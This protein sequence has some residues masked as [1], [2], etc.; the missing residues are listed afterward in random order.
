MKLR[1]PFLTLCLLLI[2][3]VPS[4]TGRLQGQ[5][6][7]SISQSILTATRSRVEPF[8]LEANSIF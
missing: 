6:P 1:I 8:S 4:G 5:Q 2:A 3:G 7:P